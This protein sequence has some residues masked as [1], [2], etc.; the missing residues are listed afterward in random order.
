MGAE[1]SHPVNFE[2]GAYK[3][4][5]NNE[6][7]FQM[8]PDTLRVPME[9][10]KEARENLGRA[11]R[12]A[13]EDYTVN[14]YLY[15]Q[16]GRNNQRFDTD[17][18][19]VIFRQE[20]YFNWL[21]GT[22]EQGLS[23][24]INCDTGESILFIPRLP[25]SYAVWSGPIRTPDWFERH[26]GVD[27]CFYTDEVV[28]VL[29]EK[30]C[31]TLFLMEGMNRF[32]YVSTSAPI[33]EGIENFTLDKT[34]MYPLAV[35]GR[36]RKTD[37]EL[38]VIRYVTKVSSEAHR[39]VM[40]AA[41]AGMM[42]YQ[43]S[44]IFTYYCYM[45]GG[46]RERGYIPICPSGDRCKLLHYG[47]QSAPNDK[48][49]QDG[50]LCLFDMG[51]EYHCYVTDITTTF[52]VN[53]KFTQVQKTTYEMVL[54]TVHAV[55]NRIRPGFTWREARIVCYRALLRNLVEQ[56]LLVGSV[57][58]MYDAKLHRIFMPHGIGHFIG[59]DVHDV[60][61]NASYWCWS[62][63]EAKDIDWYDP[64]LE[65]CPLEKNMVLTI[66][67]GCYYNNVL[68]DPALADPIQGKFMVR[69]EIDK[70]RGI[71]GVRVEEVFIVTSDGCEIISDVPRT[72]TEIEAYMKN[73]PPS[74][75]PFLDAF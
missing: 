59:G 28:A 52:P 68:L 16:G 41:K 37:K 60:G 66:E 7:Y 48:Q 57:D 26:Y 74:D 45:Y 1:Q 22:K 10:H 70:Y 33:F 24:V 27:E 69:S 43:A 2:V 61:G 29:K 19:Y 50:D 47:G 54:D 8:G 62:D 63:S 31:S 36:V 71:G 20:S 32:S 18:N 75:I 51:G 38:D 4:D 53:G 11:V 35:A 73:P 23:G 58:D 64:D 15:F 44:S 46:C 3:V 56:G 6:P 30:R 14:S 39:R 5:E 72:V 34:T 40:L 9:L 25:E 17:I 67:P 12:E 49:I 21:F 13:A 42:E 65:W 55:V